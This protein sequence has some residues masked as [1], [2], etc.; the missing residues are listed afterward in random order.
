MNTYSKIATNL[1]HSGWKKGR[2][3]A[4][5]ELKDRQQKNNAHYLNY[6]YYLPSFIQHYVCCLIS[7]NAF[8]FLLTIRVNQGHYLVS[9]HTE[10]SY[11]QG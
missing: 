9:I 1:M 4:P 11:F 10:H 2:R 7:C 6:K 3:S 5:S 8:Y